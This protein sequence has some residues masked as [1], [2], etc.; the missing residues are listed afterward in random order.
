MDRVGHWRRC[1]VSA[2]LAASNFVGEGKIPSQSFIIEMYIDF[3]QD[4]YTR[5]WNK[6]LMGETARTKRE[7][8][9][10]LQAEESEEESAAMLMQRAGLLREQARISGSRTDR[11]HIS[12]GALRASRRALSIA[13]G[14]FAKLSVANSAV[15]ASRFCKSQSEPRRV[16]RRL[17]IFRYAASSRV[18]SAA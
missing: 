9:A 10:I 2:K 15:S 5:L 7:L 8:G 17:M 4:P 18:C 14:E 6:E 13:P 3:I 16:Y 11:R 12:Q 1:I